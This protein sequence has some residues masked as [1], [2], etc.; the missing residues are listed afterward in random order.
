VVVLVGA[1]AAEP[2]GDSGQEHPAIRADA[3]AEAG[4][5]ADQPGVLVSFFPGICAI[6]GKFWTWFKVQRLRGSRLPG[7][8]RYASDAGAL[9]CLHSRPPARLFR[10][11]TARRAVRSAL[12]LSSL[13]VAA[14]RFRGRTRRV[15]TIQPTTRPTTPRQTRPLSPHTSPAP[16]RFAPSQSPARRVHSALHRSRHRHPPSPR[17]RRARSAVSRPL[18]G[19]PF[20]RRELRACFA[21]SPTEGG[22]CRSKHVL[23]GTVSQSERRPL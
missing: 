5:R 14:A 2:A 4:G 1:P 7:I 22:G 6:L 15:Q 16:R 18:L 23:T 20:T 9:T 3:A 21:G 17:L 8:A 12:R 19:A 11:E 10:F 13:A